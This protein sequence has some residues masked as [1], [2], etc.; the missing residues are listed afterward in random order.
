MITSAIHEQLT[1]LVPAQ[2]TTQHEVVIPEQVDPA[3]AIPRSDAVEGPTNQRPA[4]AGDVLPQWL[5]R[6]ESLQKD[7]RMYSTR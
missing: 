7:C 5:T 1:V 6:L 3:L 2:V 4:Q